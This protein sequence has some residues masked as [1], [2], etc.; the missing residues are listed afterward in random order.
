[1]SKYL[2]DMLLTAANVNLYSVGCWLDDLVY[3]LG[4]VKR[5]IDLPLVL[6]VLTEPKQNQDEC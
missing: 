3:S 2:N 6:V 5:A 4:C 1:M